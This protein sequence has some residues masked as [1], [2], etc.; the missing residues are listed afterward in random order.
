MKTRNLTRDDLEGARAEMFHMI[1]FAMAWVTI[2]EYTVH[3]RD[4]LV[5]AVL[6]L[7]AVIVL[8]QRST[9]FYELEGELPEA[10]AETGSEGRA[11]KRTFQRYLWMFLLEGIAIMAT[12]MVLLRVGHQEWLVSAF[13]L[14][15]GLHFFPL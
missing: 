4:F 13:A 1:L 12:W 3:F 6:V 9:R 8:G 5:P 10:P 7:I 2:G 15:A 14:I 11:R